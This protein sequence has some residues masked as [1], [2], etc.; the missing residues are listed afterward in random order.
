MLTRVRQRV[1][2]Q[3]HGHRGRV[4]ND[5]WAYR[6]LL[7][8]DGRPLSDREW[9]RLRRLFRTDDPSGQAPDLRDSEAGQR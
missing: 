2:H 8:R 9:N 6:Q 5:A 4:G 7:V 1:T 3:V